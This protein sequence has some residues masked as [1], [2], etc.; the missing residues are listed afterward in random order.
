[1]TAKAICVALVLIF[2]TGSVWADT[3]T[4]RNNVE[5]NGAVEY[6]RDAFTITGRFKG[7]KKTLTYDRRQVLSIEINAR[8]VN[9]GE[10]PISV[11]MFKQDSGIVRD[12]SKEAANN[13]GAN[14]AAQYPN[15]NGKGQPAAGSIWSPTKSDG[16]SGDV[17]VLRDKTKIVGRIILIQKGSIT[18][19]NGNASNR[20]EEERVAT[21]LIAP[22]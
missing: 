17:I 20:L 5:I 3:V 6:E 2:A 14:A 9:P 7:G 21:V 22:N 15:A 18:I 19:Q 4:L 11:S 10:P 13:T 16:I 12:G 8:D 1:M